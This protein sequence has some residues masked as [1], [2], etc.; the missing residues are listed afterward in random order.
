MFHGYDLFVNKIERLMISYENAAGLTSRRN[1]NVQH[2]QNIFLHIIKQKYHAN[3]LLLVI[4]L[5][6]LTS[7]FLPRLKIVLQSVV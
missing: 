6:S 7:C 2:M 5:R 4:L 1:S 3:T